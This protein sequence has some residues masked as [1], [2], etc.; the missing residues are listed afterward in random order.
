MAKI[1]IFI[2]VPDTVSVSTDHNP[3]L[4]DEGTSVSITLKATSENIM[5]N[6][7]LNGKQIQE[8]ARQKL[9]IINNVTTP[10]FI[11]VKST[12]SSSGDLTSSKPAC[13][14]VKSVKLA[15]QEDGSIIGTV[16]G[17]PSDVYE[18]LPY[19]MRG[20]PTSPLSPT[21]AKYRVTAW[22]EDG[23]ITTI[24]AASI[25]SDTYEKLPTSAVFKT[26]PSSIYDLYMS[27]LMTR[28]MQSPLE[29]PDS[30]V[31]IRPSDVYGTNGWTVSEILNELGISIRLPAAF[32]Y[33]VYQLSVTKGSPI[34][35]L[36]HNLLPIPGLVIERDL[37]AV[38]STDLLASYYVTVAKGKGRFKGNACKLVGSSEKTVKQRP[39]VIGLPGEPLYVDGSALGTTAD[40]DLTLNLVGGISS[41]KPSFSTV[42]TETII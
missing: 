2:N 7:L 16:S 12:V 22:R 19:V 6:I 27:N 20:A 42:H 1:P 32:N 29:S 38:T 11:V 36:V 17:L 9:V 41:I 26:I 13:C 21:T 40:G 23:A 8:Y 5:Q 39:T 15:L 35:S 24:T 25:V 31:Y 34:I 28:S 37:S 30:R 18:I 33:H 10:Q 4:V 3:L 14:G